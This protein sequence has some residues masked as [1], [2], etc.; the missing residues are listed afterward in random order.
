MKRTIAITLAALLIATSASAF[1]APDPTPDPPAPDPAPSEP[2][3]PDAPDGQHEG[4]STAC[5]HYATGECPGVWVNPPAITDQKYRGNG[6]GG[7]L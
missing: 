2:D 6:K 5:E 3:A 4:G 7:K 1:T